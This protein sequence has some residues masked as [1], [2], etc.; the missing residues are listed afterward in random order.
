MAQNRRTQVELDNIDKTPFTLLFSIY[1]ARQCAQSLVGFHKLELVKQCDYLQFD[2]IKNKSSRKQLVKDLISKEDGFNDIQSKSYNRIHIK[3]VLSLFYKESQKLKYDI[4]QIQ[5]WTSHDIILSFISHLIEASATDETPNK[6]ATAH[7]KIWEFVD[8]LR[9]Y[10]NDTQYNG[11]KF[12]SSFDSNDNN[13]N[14]DGSSRPTKGFGLQMMKSVCSKFGMKS[15]PFSKVKK[16][17]NIWAQKIHKQSKGE[18]ATSKPVCDIPHNYAN[19][20]II[21]Y[22]I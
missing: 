3:Y 21:S 20:R 14:A 9:R 13:K 4:E 17:C 1:G 7:P 15:G 8:Y 6:K 16:Q 22:S 18:C 10:F 19:L 5:N 12:L 11:E 2:N